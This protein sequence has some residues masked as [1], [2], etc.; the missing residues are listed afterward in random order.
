LNI[1]QPILHILKRISQP[2]LHILEIRIGHR[3]HQSNAKDDRQL[4]CK[5][6]IISE[7]PPF[8]NT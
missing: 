8:Y 5:F 3:S 1:S 4:R 7:S 6:V 2:I